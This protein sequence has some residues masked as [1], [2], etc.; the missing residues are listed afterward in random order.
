MQKTSKLKKVELEREKKGRQN[1][2]TTQFSP[3]KEYFQHKQRRIEKESK[4][5]KGDKI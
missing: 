2:T 5:K 3:Q 1:L 4:K